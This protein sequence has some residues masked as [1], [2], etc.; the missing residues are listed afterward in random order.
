MLLTLVRNYSLGYG[1]YYDIKI[2]GNKIFLKPI[3]IRNRDG[4]LR[5][6]D[7]SGFEDIVEFKN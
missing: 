6:G 4:S 7:L 3:Q 5:T 1:N 2:S